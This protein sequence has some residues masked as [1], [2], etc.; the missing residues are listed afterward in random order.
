MYRFGLL[1]KDFI[2]CNRGCQNQ[3]PYRFHKK[4]HTARAAEFDSDFLD[5]QTKCGEEF[6]Q[7]YRNKEIF[8]GKYQCVGVPI[9]QIQFPETSLVDTHLN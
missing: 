5:L 1:N 8:S 3:T 6:G 7:S 4:R 9:L 2:K